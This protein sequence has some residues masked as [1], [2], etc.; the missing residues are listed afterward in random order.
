MDNTLETVSLVHRLILGVALALFLVGV[1]TE[2]PNRVYDEAK[3]EI[4][5]LTKGM[6]GVSELVDKA[7]K[8]IYDQ[9][10]L[11]SGTLAWLRQHQGKQQDVY[12]DVIQPADL[13]VPDSE[14]DPLVTLEAQVKWADR[15]YR[16]L[17]FPFL[18]CDVGR[19]QLTRALDKRFGV[20]ATPT[21]RQL[22]VYLRDDADGAKAGRQFSCVIEVKYQVRSGPLEGNRSEI[23][24]VPTTALQVTKVASADGEQID[25]EIAHIFKD[26]ELGDFEDT[27]AVLVPHLWKLW[28]DVAGRSPDAATAFLEQ[29]KQDE[30]EKLKEKI[31]I[32]GE[33]LSRSV[34]IIMTS[35]VLLCLMAYLL[36][37]MIQVHRMVTGNEAA[38][39]E[40]PFYGIMC[41]R[42]G[43]LVILSTLLVP[44]AVCVFVL[45]CVFPSLRAEWPG[46]GWI[47][48][49]ETRWLLI[50]LLGETDL[51][52][53]LQARTTLRSL[54]VRPPAIHTGN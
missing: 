6:T 4:Q 1:S 34:T 35:F 36:V 23:L 15:I 27:R 25:L 39:S 45:L 47:V 52:L 53:I 44:F 30:A 2:H 28:S 12:V 33:S 43:Q 31:E 8:A 48:S 11:K 40:S 51:L 20:S 10:E 37:H 42:L 5:T 38:V 49:W 21:V 18:L 29:K 7:Y 17:D 54:K 24:D 13:V 46:P 19:P 22:R 14:R 32:L 9:S 16:D 41:T 50:L 26:G 3:S